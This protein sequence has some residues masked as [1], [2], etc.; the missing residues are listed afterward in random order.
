MELFEEALWDAMQCMKLA[1]EE[2]GRN[3]QVAHQMFVKSHAKK[4]L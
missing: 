4:L 1:E 2:L 3:A